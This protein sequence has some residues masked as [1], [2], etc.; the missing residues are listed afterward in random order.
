LVHV[1]LQLGQVLV[2]LVRGHICC[3]Y[4]RQVAISQIL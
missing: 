1:I 2:Q 4:I 3:S